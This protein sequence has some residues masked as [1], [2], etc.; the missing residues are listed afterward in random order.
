MYSTPPNTSHKNRFPIVA[1][2]SILA[3]VMLLIYVSWLLQSIEETV[4]LEPA[5]VEQ[6]IQD[7]QQYPLVPQKVEEV[8]LEATAAYVWDVNL[9]RP[10]F[11]KNENTPLPLA[12]I[13]KLM[14]SLLAYELVAG[15]ET[16][17]VPLSAIRQEGSSGLTAGEQ[18]ELENLSQLALVSSSNDAAYALGAS[19]GSLLGENDPH[20][21]FVLGMNLKADEMGLHTLDFNNTTGLD[22]SSTTPGA[23]GSAKDATFLMEHLLRNYPE[24]LEPTR[25]EATL[26]YNTEGAYHIA[27]NTNPVVLDIPNILG[28][29]TGYTDLAGGNLTVAFDAGLNR[30]IIV[31]VLGSTRQ[32]RFTDVMTLIQKVQQNLSEPK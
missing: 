1:Q 29:K 8:S 28:S 16:M 31:T 6:I 19:V 30:P 11:A 27:N 15:D 23:V 32:A 26:I 22:E 4:P 24:L 12:S 14:T 20:S 3:V 7:N 13:T 18:M 21:Q 2:L 25:T 17:S 5:P 10:L 9:Q